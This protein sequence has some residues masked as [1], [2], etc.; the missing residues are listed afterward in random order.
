MMLEMAAGMVADRTDGSQKAGIAATGVTLTITS[1]AGRT[2][3]TK[4]AFTVEGTDNSAIAM[5]IVT[6]TTTTGMTM[7][8][9]P[10]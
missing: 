6:A 8:V 7:V 4:T 3:A 2:G 10:I 5:T 1:I 9:A